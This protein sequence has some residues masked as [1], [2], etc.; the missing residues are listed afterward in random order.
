MGKK[1][2]FFSAKQFIAGVIICLS[3][4]FAKF[5]LISNEFPINYAYNEFVEMVTNY[6][7]VAAVLGSDEHAYYKI[8][9]SNDVPLGIPSRDDKD[10]DGIVCE[11]EEPCSSLNIKYPTW[12]LTSGGGGTP[13]YSEE[14]TPWNTHL[15]KNGSEDYYYTSQYNMIIFKSSSTGLSAEAY[16]PYSQM[17]DKVENLMSHKY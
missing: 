4:F 14:K 17:I 5:V 11:N 1:E 2:S 12:F 9:I 15:K 13:Y 8:R 7:K 3:A 16:N 6:K 10:G